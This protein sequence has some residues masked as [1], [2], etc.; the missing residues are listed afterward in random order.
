M[1][2]QLVTPIIKKITEYLK[3]SQNSGGTWRFCFENGIL[4]DAYMIILLRLLE[5]EDKQLINRLARR[6]ISKQTA[7]GTWK[8]FHD[9]V[10]G[11][12]S[13]T[14]EA[15]Y[16]LLFSGHKHK[17]DPDML[18]AKQFILSQ[19]GP[20]KAGSLTKVM[21][22]LTGHYPW[23]SFPKIPVEII[24]LPTWSPV[25]FFDFV[26][27]ARVHSAPI[28]ICADKKFSLTHPELPDLSDL[29]AVQPRPLTRQVPNIL[30]E[31]I[32]ELQRSLPLIPEQIHNRA[33]KKMEQFMLDR[34]E[35]D[36]T[37]YSY[38][39][40]TFIMIFALL[41]LNY[42]KDHPVIVKS[43]R[44]LKSFVYKINDQYDHQQE[45][46]STVWDT[47]LI[48][49]V[50]QEAGTPGSDP[51]V[52]KAAQ[53]LLNRQHKKYGDWQ[54]HNPQTEPG[55]WGFSDINTI[56]PDVD[57]TSYSLRALYPLIQAHPETYR[58]P[59]EKGLKWLLSM[60]NNDGGW[61]AFEKNTN[62][63]WVLKLPF[64]DAKPV[65]TDPSSTDLTG[66]TLEFLGNYAQMT[67]SHKQIR[68]AVNWLLENQ[69]P[70]GSWY[71][72]WGISYI[73]GTW[74][75]VTGLIAVGIK[76]EH[77]AIK[78]A[79]NWLLSIQ[80]PD[81]GW[82]ESCL[83][84]KEQRFIPLK[85]STPSQTAWALDTLITSG[86]KTTE[87]VK[88]G[89]NT[90]ILSID[91]NDWTTEYPTGAGLPGGFYINYHSYRYIWPLLA[92]THFQKS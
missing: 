26:G 73:Y 68:K 74:S 43:I 35:S 36:G 52:K 30:Q 22:A 47:A 34:I 63:K 92:L 59:W 64:T 86:Y 83:S 24:L 60:Q 31:Q 14:I 72:R 2:E 79:I 41:A 66:R 76:P 7:N 28:I 15:Y 46:T 45:T 70:D 23:N 82:G 10:D 57:D 25:N 85:A 44:G 58:I 90:L 84:D 89:I 40:S 3:T 55:G 12:L 32:L 80:N 49:C 51:A 4:T 21:L 27:Y 42:P 16:A 62:K 19:G 17:D 56:N 65:L 48:T 5:I 1:A 20:T 9:Q 29:F 61:P 37:L 67:L 6:I 8:L 78:K 77:A 33:L 39:T 50:L 81:G 53:Y 75:A 91:K 88:R 11:D 71:G 13:A 38:F 54:V 87:A 18:R 69:E